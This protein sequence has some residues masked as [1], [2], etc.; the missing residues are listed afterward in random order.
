MELT[1]N[2]TYTESSGLFKGRSVVDWLFAALL[3]A[4]AL[5]AFL[6]GGGYAIQRAVMAALGAVID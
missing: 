5:F 6:V 1:D 4:G 3:L 2:P